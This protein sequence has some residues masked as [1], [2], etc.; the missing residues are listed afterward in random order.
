MAFEG[1]EALPHTQPP[2][3]WGENIIEISI[4]NTSS[5][6]S[7]GELIKI[8]NHLVYFGVCV[9]LMPKAKAKKQFC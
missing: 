2:E 6:K 1:L 5:T 8:V 4:S 9:K 7:S 3:D